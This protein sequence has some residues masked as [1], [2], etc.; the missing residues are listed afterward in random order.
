MPLSRQCHLRGAQ[1]HGAHQAA[2]HIPAV[3]LPS[4]SRYSF[5]DPDRMEGWVSPGRGAESN[6][7]T[8]A[9]RL[10]VAGLSPAGRLEPAGSWWLEYLTRQHAQ[11]HPM[12]MPYCHHVVMVSQEHCNGTIQLPES[13]QH[14]DSSCRHAVSCDGEPRTMLDYTTAC[15]KFST[16]QHDVWVLQQL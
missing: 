15:A 9:T 12:L 8:V 3:D 2:L 14:R 11:A 6:W 10:R 4:C 13:I 7:P 16:H 1:V 5:T